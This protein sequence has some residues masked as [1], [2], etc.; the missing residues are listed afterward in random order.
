MKIVIGQGNPGEKYTNTRHNIGW[1]ILDDYANRQ[2][3]E[4]TNKSKFQAHIAELTVAG[5]KVLLVKPTTFY[6]ETGLSARSLIDFY[7]LNSTDVLTIHDDISLPLGSVRVRGKGSDAGNNG[8]KSLNAHI[9]PDYWRLKIGIYSQLRDRMHDADFV[10]SRFSI[11]EMN[12]LVK[13]IY[14]QSHQII[15]SFIGGEHQP[16]SFSVQTPTNHEEAQP[17]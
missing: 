3:V 12:L 14:K 4:F 1:L 16:T 5:E 17:E 8:I 10:L 9:G 6:N 15:D 2:G 11:D 13:E 7:K